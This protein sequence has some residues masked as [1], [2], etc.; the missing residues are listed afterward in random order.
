LHVWGRH[1]ERRRRW[2]TLFTLLGVAFSAL[3]ALK[4]PPQTAFGNRK[5]CLPAALKMLPSKKGLYGVGG[6]IAPIAPRG[7]ATESNIVF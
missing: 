5:H 3:Q 2:K 4:M 7:S 1:L 6:A